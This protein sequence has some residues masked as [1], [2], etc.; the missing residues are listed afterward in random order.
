MSRRRSLVAIVLVTATT[1]GIAACGD[2]SGSS[3]E[4]SATTAAASAIS[5]AAGPTTTAKA[6]AGSA[7][8]MAAGAATTAKPA[9]GGSSGGSS[10]AQAASDFIA[11]V[12]AVAKGDCAT[13]DRLLSIDDDI[14]PIKNRDTFKDLANAFEQLG[15]SGPAEVRADFATLAKGVS[16][17]AKALDGIDLS[18]PAQFAKALSDPKTASAIEAAQTTMNDGQFEAAGDR[19]T[20]WSE[21]KCP[22]LATATTKA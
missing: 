13:A 11:A 12:N 3:S 4:T 2:D 16:A 8:T 10:S 22:N 14:D 21:K 6:A 17:L 18:D 19:I 7:T 1:I 5:A 20:A 9:S 15:S